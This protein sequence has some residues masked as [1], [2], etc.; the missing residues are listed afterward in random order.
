MVGD[1]R[2][3]DRAEIDCFELAEL[4]DAILGHHA[5][6]LVVGLAGPVEFSPIEVDAVFAAGCLESANALGHDFLSD[7]VAWNYC[8]IDQ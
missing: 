3:A 2:K 8:D 6:G 1:A 5:T 7:A 4:F